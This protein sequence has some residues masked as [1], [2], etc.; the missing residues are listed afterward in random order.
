MTGP[1]SGGGPSTGVRQRSGDV[2]GGSA[3]ALAS[4]PVELT[5]VLIARVNRFVY[6]GLGGHEIWHELRQV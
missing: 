3:G 1:S 5:F 2:V 6:Y 4:D